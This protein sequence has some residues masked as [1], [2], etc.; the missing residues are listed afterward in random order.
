M[1][2]NLY[3]VMRL[4]Q[5]LQNCSFRC[6]LLYMMYSTNNILNGQVHP[7]HNPYM[8]IKHPPHLISI[9]RFY[10]RNDFHHE[11][12]PVCGDILIPLF[13]QQEC[14]HTWSLPISIKRTQLWVQDQRRD[15]GWTF[16][17]GITGC[18]FF[19][20]WFLI[21]II[22]IRF[23]CH[24][25]LESE[26]EPA[27]TLAPLRKFYNITSFVP[28]LQSLG[29]PPGRAVQVVSSNFYTLLL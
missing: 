5:L 1:R 15:I 2:G 16:F 20:M 29:P 27:A 13:A 11:S 3:H 22:V 7:I 10:K 26:Y 23:T 21:F 14:G 24:I 8:D 18:Y 28:H 4:T 12:F 9:L 17:Y 6:T 19:S 25:L